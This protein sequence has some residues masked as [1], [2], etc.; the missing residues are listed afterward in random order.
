MSEVKVEVS[1]DEVGMDQ[2]R[3]DRI[4]RHFRAYVDDGRL[5]GWSVL[6]SRANKVAYVATYGSSDL[7]AGRQ[8]DE[9]TLFR[10]FSMTKPITSVALM[11]LYEE[12][13]VE[14]TDPVSKYIPSFASCRVFQKG[15]S[16]APVTVPVQ[17]DVRIWHLLTHTSGLTYGFHYAH[18]CD[19]IYRMR[20]YEW[21]VP[22]EFD[23]AQ[24]C[25]G[26][27]SMPL[28]F[29]P[30]SEWNYSVATD[31]VGRVVEVVS[32]MTLDEFFRTRIFEPLKMNDTHFL[33]PEEDVERMA[34]LYMPSPSTG[35]A[36]RFDGM[37][38]KPGV[39]PRYLSGG[40]GLISSLGDYHR[41]TQML[42]N[43]GEL[44]GVR[45]L[46]SR[47]V[48]YMTVNHLPG[49]ADLTAFGRPIFA[50]TS[51]NGVGFGLGFSVV[52]DPTAA[53]TSASAGQFAWGGAASTTFWV[54]P[55]EEI[56]V[57]FMTQLLPS[58]TYP[59]RPQ[60]AQLVYQALVD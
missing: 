14:L 47:T 56:T 57:I 39:R 41:F 2:E 24:A 26:F 23:L 10:I 49:N 36:T 35:K 19:A 58:S 32:G 27:A 45:L 54:D 18:P 50:E 31:V 53:K 60:L 51:Y 44:D 22:A 7:E 46:G 12:G 42:L 9:A 52:M 13:L 55:L 43:E 28:V 3:L 40:G 59:I 33:L 11:M 15:S 30:G 8:V 17:E 4:E 20:G 1:A 16:S 25:D 29:E 21:G 38:P 5:P 37:S 34:A 6:V 48:E